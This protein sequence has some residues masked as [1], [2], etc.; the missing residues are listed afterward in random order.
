[1]YFTSLHHKRAIHGFGGRMWLPAV[2]EHED[3]FYIEK[4]VYQLPRDQWPA[5]VRRLAGAMFQARVKYVTIHKWLYPNPGHYQWVTQILEDRTFRK[6][7]QEYQRILR[8]YEDKTHLIYR[9]VPYKT[10][11]ERI[12]SP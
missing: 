7:Q 10:W 4:M 8:V 3:P 6:N 9:L 12:K 11:P 2:W 1:M 5:Y